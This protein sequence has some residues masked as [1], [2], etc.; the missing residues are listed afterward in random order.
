MSEKSIDQNI[1]PEV[2]GTARC[3]LLPEVTLKLRYMPL[4]IEFGLYIFPQDCIGIPKHILVHLSNPSRFAYQNYHCSIDRLIVS[5]IDRSI[6]RSK[7]FQQ[8][9]QNYPIP[10]KTANS[11][12]L[13]KK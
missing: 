8:N 6:D 1:F 10:Y 7:K 12:G 3:V 9:S 11:N 4:E 2:L 5:S 13:G